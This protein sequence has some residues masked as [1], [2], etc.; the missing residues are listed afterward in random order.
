MRINRYL[1]ECG[2]CSRR[3][4]DK[5]VED[6]FVRIN[7]KKAILGDVVKEGDKVFAHG[8]LVERVKEKFVIAYHKPP[9]VVCTFEPA[10]NDNLK[11]HLDIKERYYYIGRLDR[12]SE[13][14]LLLTN[15][16]DIVNP[17]LRS[18]EEKEKE[19][20][21]TY[22]Q[23]PKEEQIKKM[24]AG[25][26]IGDDRGLTKP[27]KITK[28]NAQTYKIILTEGRNRQIRKMAVAVGLRVT[29]LKRMR[30]MFIELGQLKSGAFRYLNQDELNKLFKFCNLNVNS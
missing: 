21:V 3:A 20:W 11:N 6:G 9:G 26:D 2:L 4:A 13:G 15:I 5:M 28:I 8:K 12:E 7:N 18:S 16:G 19:Y 23:K 22:L 25:V 17:I 27:C 14:L 10:E 30:V 1:A 29:Q 24:A